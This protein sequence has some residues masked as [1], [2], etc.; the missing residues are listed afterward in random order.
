MNQEIKTCKLDSG[1]LIGSQLR[2]PDVSPYAEAIMSRYPIQIPFYLSTS[3]TL[4]Q[5]TIPRVRVSQ[6]HRYDA[7]ILG[8]SASQNIATLLAGNPYLQVTHLQTGIPWV[9]PHMLAYAPLPAFV[10]FPGFGQTSVAKLPEAFFL[11]RGTQLKFEWFGFNLDVTPAVVVNLTMVGVQLINHAPSF[12]APEKITM[13]N[14]D[15]IPVGSRL[16]WFGCVPFGGRL[17]TRSLLTSN[18]R[19]S[20]LTQAISYVPPQDC[21][22]EIHDA[23]ASFLNNSLFGFAGDNNLLQAKIDDTQEKADWTPTNTPAPAMFGQFGAVSPNLPFVKPYLLKADHKL[24]MTAL[25]NS[26][27]NAVIQG[28]VTFRGVRL[29]QY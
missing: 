27:S 8:M 19:L 26:T 23:F 20:A 29:C 2:G 13:P 4:D 1:D 15:E 11:P 28:T 22:V 10:G 16:P 3:I 7:L 6:P 17:T 25:N 5:N 14:G 9:S 24:S 12:S 21:N 18:F